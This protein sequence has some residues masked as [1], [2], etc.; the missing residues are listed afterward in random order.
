MVMSRLVE[1]LS[2]KSLPDYMSVADSLDLNS[3]SYNSSEEN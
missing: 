3:K 1:F 2:P